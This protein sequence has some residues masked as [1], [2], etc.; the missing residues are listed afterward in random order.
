MAEVATVPVRL[1]NRI[2]IEALE[3]AI[4]WKPPASFILSLDFEVYEIPKP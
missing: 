2:D 3:G 1:K 4:D